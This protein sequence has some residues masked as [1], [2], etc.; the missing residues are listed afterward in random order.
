MQ[1]RAVLVLLFAIAG[2]VSGSTQ[3]R[4]ARTSG[5]VLARNTSAMVN[6][7]NWVTSN[8]GTPGSLAVWHSYR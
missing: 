7:G 3:Q 1:H 6:N 2:A 8:S 5:F 4:N